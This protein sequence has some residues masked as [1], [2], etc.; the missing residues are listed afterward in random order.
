MDD[1]ISGCHCHFLVATRK[2]TPE[3]L[4]DAIPMSFV[5][6]NRHRESPGLAEL[7]VDL[8]EKEGRPHM[9]ETDWIKLCKMVHKTS[10]TWTN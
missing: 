9:N 10:H 3:Q 7:L 8:W 2:I 6:T 1:A 4:L 5:M